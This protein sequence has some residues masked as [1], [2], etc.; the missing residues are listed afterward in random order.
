MLSNKNNHKVESVLFC[1]RTL[2]KLSKIESDIAF[3]TESDESSS[4]KRYLKEISKTHKVK[5]RLI[6][7]DLRKLKELKAPIS[8][9]R[10]RAFKILCQ[11]KF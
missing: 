10:S 4:I 8:Y 11:P 1:T 7:Q 6:K 2:L 5:A 9:E 3:N